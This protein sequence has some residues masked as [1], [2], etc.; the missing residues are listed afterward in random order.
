MKHYIFMETN[1]L[2]GTSGSIL[3]KVAV[4]V[5]LLLQL[6]RCLTYDNIRMSN[7]SDYTKVLVGK[8]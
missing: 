2:R 3:V 4:G 8:M 5:L 7:E 1:K 6:D